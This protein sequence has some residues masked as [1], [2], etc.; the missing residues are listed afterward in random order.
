[1]SDFLPGKTASSPVL[2]SEDEYR[3]PVRQATGFARWFPSLTFYVKAFGIVYRSLKPAEQGL[4]TDEDWCNDSRGEVYSI[5][6]VGGRL[7]AE[8]LNHVRELKEPCLIVGNHMSTLETFV[9]PCMIQPWKPVTFVVK[10]SLLTYPFFGSIMRSREP[11]VVDRR[12]P[13]ED[14]EAVLRYGQ[15]R[16][17]RGISIVV[18]PQSTRMERFDPQQFNTIGIK[19]ARKAKVPIIPLALR[20]DFWSN[21]SII[22]DVG[23]VRPE[24]TVHFRF[25][26]PL[27]ITG[28]G[29][30]EHNQ[31]IAFIQSSLA[32]WEEA[33]RLEQM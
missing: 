10:R 2:F 1:M 5:E 25:G 21:G 23:W 18:F 30:D 32:E 33:D 3:S 26:T 4:Y 7:E 8:G 27:R 31:I 20:T 9:L 29:K 24:R 22:K 19:L 11:V 14:L 28:S 13:R 12:N 15:E 17:Q 6:Q 16:L